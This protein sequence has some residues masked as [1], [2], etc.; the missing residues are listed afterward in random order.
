MLSSISAGVTKGE[1]YGQMEVLLMMKKKY[2]INK[3]KSSSFYSV[4]DYFATIFLVR[5]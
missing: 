1:F 2:C 3:F 5:L 4:H